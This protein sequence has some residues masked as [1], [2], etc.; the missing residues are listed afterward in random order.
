MAF[1]QYNSYMDI[2]LTNEQFSS[3][4][5]D[6]TKLFIITASCRPGA[7]LWMVDLEYNHYVPDTPRNNDFQLYVT[8]WEGMSWLTVSIPIED[9]H[10]AEDVASKYHLK[11]ADGIP[12]MLFNGTSNPFPLSGDNVWTLESSKGIFMDKEEEEKLI[13]Q[14]FAGFKTNENQGS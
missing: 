14:I 13:E 8:Q 9:R 7:R 4:S 11:L 1:S 6:K 10:I 2:D 3:L 12:M 5:D